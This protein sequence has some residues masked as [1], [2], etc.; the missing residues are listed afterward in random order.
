VCDGYSHHWL[1]NSDFGVDED[2]D[3]PPEN[4]I[5]ATHVCKHCNAVGNEC[6]SCDGEGCPKCDGEGVIEVP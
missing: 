4:R 6:E 1:D 5:D 2:P 3:F